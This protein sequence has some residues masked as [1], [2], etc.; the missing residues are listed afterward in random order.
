MKKWCS[1]LVM[2]FVLALA[3]APQS[4]LALSRQDKI[5]SL[6]NSGVVSGYPDG[7]LGLD[8]PISRAELAVL[9]T[10]IKGPDLTGQASPNFKDV[11]NNYWAKPYIDKACFLKNP[12]GV[13]AIVG[14]PNGTFG[15]DRNISNIE[16]IKILVAA[17]KS[18]L[19]PW[20][21]ENASWP[22]SWIQWSIDMKIL[23]PNSGLPKLSAQASA[24]R[25]DVF[26]MI[27]NAMESNFQGP[28]PKNPNKKDP[29]I[30]I[31]GKIL[32]EQ[33]PGKQAPK[34]SE[35]KKTPS[36]NTANAFRDF[37]SGKSFDHK[38]FQMQFLALVNADRRRLGLEDLTWAQDL[39]QACSIRTEELLKNGSIDVDGRVHVRLDGRPWSTVLDYLQ[40]QILTTPHGENLA[41][42][43]QT[44]SSQK[45]SARSLKLMTN[46]SFLAQTFYTMW[47][48]SPGH[49]ANMM[50]PNYQ[51]LN[52][53]I[54]VGNYSK[55]SSPGQNTVFFVGTTLFRG[56]Y[57]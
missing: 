54:R 14:Y 11:P 5:N 46:E 29:E 48:N 15:P 16:M 31:P 21:V 28:S 7:T 3:L 34:S 55:D 47:W 37:N 51:Y 17:N 19:T 1:Y 24:K 18:D 8:K 38:K 44:S 49:R 39:D 30:K 42:M 36:P 6:K 40:P 23:G 9:L 52:V 32:P 22:L 20:D 4:V 26:T 33:G 13:P 57:R 25:G 10:K 27:Y 50:N 35:S 56:E 2:V 43:T 45:I 53:K 12:H 41:D